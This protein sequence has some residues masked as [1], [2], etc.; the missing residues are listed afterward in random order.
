M[1]TFTKT[2]QRVGECSIGVHRH[3]A[4]NV[5]ENIRL[6]Q[7]IEF[8][9]ATD[10]DRCWELPVTEAIENHE[11]WHLSANGFSLKSRGWAKKLVYIVQ[12]RDVLGIESKALNSA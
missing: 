7:V 2:H 11:C 6:G 3:M 1:R 9:A 10:S 5:V 12:M 8:V 4:S